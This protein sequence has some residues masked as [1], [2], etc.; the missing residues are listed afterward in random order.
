MLIVFLLLL[1]MIVISFHEEMKVVIGYEIALF[2]GYGLWQLASW[3]K[4]VGFLIIALILFAT[5]RRILSVIL[6]S[7]RLF[8]E[9]LIN[10]N[11]KEVTFEDIKHEYPQ[12]N[13]A[14]H[15]KVYDP[16]IQVN[17]DEWFYVFNKQTYGPISEQELLKLFQERK[18][19]PN[20]AIRWSGVKHWSLAN[21]IWAN[22][23]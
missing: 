16:S 17:T 21:N 15:I 11:E 5:S 12:S 2:I 4:A 8:G 13:P 10:K 18:L 1:L 14:P 20:T 19:P 3:W 6:Q 22:R 7:I 9:L 23:F